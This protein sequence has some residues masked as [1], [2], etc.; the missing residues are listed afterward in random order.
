MHLRRRA[1]RQDVGAPRALLFV[2]PYR[3]IFRGAHRVG[4]AV[5][6]RNRLFQA[7]WAMRLHDGLDR[8]AQLGPVVG[9][10]L[11][12]RRLRVEDD[13]HAVVVVRGGV[14]LLQRLLFGPVEPRR[15]HVRRR[16]ARRVVDQE[17][18]MLAARRV[19]VKTESHEREDQPQRRQN[20]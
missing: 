7:C 10:P 16:H 5:G 19:G 9:V 14:D 20:L 8:V 3:R 4:E 15:R 6:E 12:R 17:D 11:Q 2:R 18:V 13:D 1:L